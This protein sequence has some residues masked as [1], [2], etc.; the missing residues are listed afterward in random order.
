[1]CLALAV[2]DNNNYVKQHWWDLTSRCVLL[3]QPL[4]TAVW[5]LS[6]SYLISASGIPAQCFVWST[7]SVIGCLSFVLMLW[8]KQDD[9]FTI[10]SETPS[11]ND[12]GFTG[13]STFNPIGRG[14]VQ[15][16][17]DVCGIVGGVYLCTSDTP[18]KGHY[19]VPGH[20]L[21]YLCHPLHVLDR[22][23]GY[24]LPA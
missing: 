19:P 7:V 8:F 9:A 18:T 1:M 22:S 2:D 23:H 10:P 4:Q 5:G 15:E 12:T 13:W 6:D 16:L 3:T 11:C 17:W 14:I 24:W 20:L 21:P